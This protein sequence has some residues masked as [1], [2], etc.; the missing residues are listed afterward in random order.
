MVG[1]SVLR[2][3]KFGARVAEEELDAL[4]LYFVRTSQWQSIFDGDVDVIY[5]PKG[6]GKSALYSLL[7]KRTV[8]LRE[9]GIVIVNAENPRGTPAFKY[10][11][12]DP[13]STE[14]DFISM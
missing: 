13:P 1:L 12:E 2:S 5:G 10:L 7:I 14:R 9:R 3:T 8:E 6:S 4:E 11:E